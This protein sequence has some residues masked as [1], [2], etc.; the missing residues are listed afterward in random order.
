MP[1]RCR[2]GSTTRCPRPMPWR[3]SFARAR[4]SL[5]DFERTARELIVFYPGASALQLAP[6]GVV[7]NSHPLAGNEQAIGH[8]LFSDPVR[9]RAAFKARD[10]GQLTLAGPFSLIQGGTGAVGRLPVFLD[11]DA[12]NPRLLGI[13]LG[14]DSLSRRAQVPRSSTRSCTLGLPV[15]A[16]AGSSG[17]RKEGSDRRILGRRPGSSGGARSVKVADAV[18]TLGVVP[19]R[20]WA[21][22]LGFAANSAIGLLL[23]LLLATVAKLLVD[24]KIASGR[25]GGARGAPHRRGR[26]ARGGAEPCAGHRPCRELGLGSRPAVKS[27]GR[28]RPVA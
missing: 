9:N 17:L 19:T 25:A 28:R 3:P 2:R 7:S 8:D 16:L 26:R 5:R 13:H 14:L 11:D 12:G 1:S 4:A 6:R 24:L 15:Q 21:N 27:S 20:G 18:W 10:T 23:S 22:P